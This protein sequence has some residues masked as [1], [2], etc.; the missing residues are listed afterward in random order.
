MTIHSVRSWNI[1][2]MW[3]TP[4]KTKVHE[5]NAKQNHMISSRTQCH[6]LL[7]DKALEKQGTEGGAVVKLE[8]TNAAS[9]GRSGST[10]C[11][12]FT[13]LWPVLICQETPD[14][15]NSRWLFFWLVG[16][17]TAEIKFPNE[18]KAAAVRTL[19]AKC[20]VHEIAT[21]GVYANVSCA[22]VHSNCFFFL[23]FHVDFYIKILKM[24]F[25]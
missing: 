15:V 21:F 7:Y 1:V 4:R 19:V 22:S 9:N 18:T 13:K 6:S 3:K 12:P 17:C 20:R 8:A 10:I 11:S 24:L 25:F 5:R 16:K 14:N 23:E 2:W